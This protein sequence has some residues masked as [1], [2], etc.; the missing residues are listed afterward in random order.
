MWTNAA[1]SMCGRNGVRLLAELYTCSKAS[2]QFVSTGVRRVE[3]G[4]SFP[5]RDA[6]KRYQRA[7]ETARSLG[8]GVFQLFNKMGHEQLMPWT[9]KHSLVDKGSSLTVR[10]SDT[11][12]CT[13]K[14]RIHVCVKCMIHMNL[15]LAHACSS[16]RL[17]M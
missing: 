5:T 1:G 13:V 4:S 15:R 9:L 17:E 8:R 11:M 16:T 2:D 7:L 3:D 6:P 10:C 12:T 14:N